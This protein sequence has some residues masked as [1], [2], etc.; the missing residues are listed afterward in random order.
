MIQGSKA[1]CY[2][3]QQEAKAH[4][5]NTKIRLK[6]DKEFVIYATENRNPLKFLSEGTTKRIAFKI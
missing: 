5:K 4:I 1:I 2:Q 6:K 3:F